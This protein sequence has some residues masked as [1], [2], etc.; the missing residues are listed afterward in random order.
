LNDIKYIDVPIGL[1][2]DTIACLTA[3]KYYMKL[4]GNNKQY[5]IF[6]NFNLARISELDDY[7]ICSSQPR[8]G[9]VVNKEELVNII[10]FGEDRPTRLLQHL[11][12]NALYGFVH[13]PSTIPI[14]EKNYI[15]FIPKRENPF[16]YLT[17]KFVVI[18]CSYTDYRRKFP[19]R[20]VNDMVDFFVKSNIPVVFS[21]VSKHIYNKNAIYNLYDIDY[22]KG[23]NIIDKL[24]IENMLM[25]FSKAEL[26]ISAD[27]GSVHLAGM[28]E[29]PILS[30]CTIGNPFY[31]API[32]HNMIGWN[33]MCV[34]PTVDCKD[35]CTREEFWND[36]RRKNEDAD[37]VKSLKTE[38]VMVYL[39]EFKRHIDEGNDCGNQN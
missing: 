39:E 14:E 6:D 3:A 5:Q 1:L 29:I 9:H 21:G 16:E 27:G 13:D 20:I 19:D 23:I 18:N 24:S 15:K 17:K 7:C 8:H 33:Y 32:R 26:F 31:V 25:L 36:C 34:R 28:T 12:D 35:C 22:T 37:C 30:F 2:G 38:D 4:N 11:V 10:N